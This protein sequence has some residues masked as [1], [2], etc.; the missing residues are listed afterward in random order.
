MVLFEPV[1]GMLQ[2]AGMDG[3]EPRKRP[4]RR[5]GLRGMMV[6]VA[7]IALGLVAILP[8]F[9]ERLRFL[10]RYVR[11]KLNEDDLNRHANIGAVRG[12]AEDFTRAIRSGHP[13]EA[14]EFTTSDFRKRMTPDG[15]RQVASRIGLDRGPCEV[16]Q[17]TIAFPEGVNR[18]VS[19]FD[20]RCG[21][22]EAKPALVKLIVVT[23]GGR[24]KVDR[25]EAGSK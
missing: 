6:L 19:E 4:R 8:L 18:F 20:L 10:E 15:L 13:Q 3:N 23:E 2:E 16:V 12:L 11:V 22:A 25:V 24:L 1:A 5:F 14:L 21:R 9:S 17:A 7:L